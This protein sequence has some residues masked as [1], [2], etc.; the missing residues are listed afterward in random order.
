MIK[1]ATLLL[2]KAYRVFI[3]PFM[4]NCCRFYPSCS[5]YAAEAIER[6]GVLC[7]GWLVFKRLLRCHP[8]YKEAGYDPVPD[9][10]FIPRGFVREQSNGRLPKGSYPERS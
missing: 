4:G 5:V 10:K 9:L 6:Y 1:K 2:I 7:G 3:S 8:W